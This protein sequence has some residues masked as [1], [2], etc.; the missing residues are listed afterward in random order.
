M[1]ELI[2]S[3]CH[4]DDDRYADDR[5]AVLAR[6]QRAGVRQWVVPAVS[7][8]RWPGLT[9]LAEQHEGV[10]PAYGLHP[11]FL[12]DHLAA[13]LDALGDYL[14]AHQAVA[15]GECGLDFYLTHLDRDRQLYFLRGQLDLARDLQLPVILHSRKAVDE[16]TREL[17][18]RPQVR[19][20]LHSFS[21]SEQQAQR[22]ADMGCL[23]GF[24]GPLTYPRAQRLQRLVKCLPRE[25]LLIETD[26]P[27]QPGAYARGQRHEPAHLPEI[28]HFM[29]QLLGDDPRELSMTLN[30]NTCRLFGLS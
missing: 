27:D 16:I 18:R 23:L 17:R 12:G 10:F 21:G 9:A 6:S 30:A 19:A 22:L 11:Y 15:I 25:A 1:I 28:L 26:A 2:D 20:N 5:E 14:E 29:A 8:Q 13:D 7:R 24:G 4:L 3:H